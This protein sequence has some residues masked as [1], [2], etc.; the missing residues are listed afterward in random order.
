M[1]LKEENIKLIFGLKIRQLRQEKKLSL[2]ELSQESGLSISYLNEIEKGK[3]YP[4]SD[5]IASLSEALNIPYDNL[6]SLKLTKKLAPFADLLNSSF[7]G[8]V[9]LELFGIESSKLVELFYN[10]PIKVNAFIGALI[11]IARNYEMSKEQ[12]YFAILR[13]YQELHDNYFEDLE[14]KSDEFIIENSLEDKYF[15]TVNTLSEILT[16]K[17]NYI[18]KDDELEKHPELSDFRSVMIP[19]KPNVLLINKNL[20]ESQ[21]VFI[22]ARELGYKYLN[23]NERVYTFTWLKVNSF[24]QTLNN[25]KASYF[26]GALL[27]NRKKI[28]AEFETIF[29]KSTWEADVFKKLMMQFHSSPETF[30]HRLTNILPTYFN[31]NNLFFLRLVIDEK[32]VGK[33]VINKELHLGR[34]HDPHANLLHEHYCQGWISVRLLELLN[35]RKETGKNLEPLVGVQKSKYVDSEHEYFCIAFAGPVNDDKN[36]CVTIG[37]LMNNEFKKKVNFWNDTQIPTRKVGV[38]CERCSFSECKVR[39]VFASVIA[40]EKKKL[41]IESALT[42]IFQK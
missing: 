4:K 27:I 36:A 34:K 25:Y 8:E 41:E 31:I 29:S 17:Y 1:K 24:E 6:V 28:V 21:K 23:L 16:N 19:G 7:L 18:I 22:L 3:K 30:M 11:E 40:E 13:S 9:P 37:F 12:F 10:A 39:S 32:N 20:N 26:A 35:K 5:K 2:S 42:R 15:I 14:A 33:Y 38:T